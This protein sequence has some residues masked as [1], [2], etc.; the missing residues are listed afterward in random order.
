MLEVVFEFFLFPSLV[1]F[2]VFRVLI[3]FTSIFYLFIIMW[4]W[5]A[6]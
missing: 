6:I 2:Y 4:I 3:G 1:E 5:L